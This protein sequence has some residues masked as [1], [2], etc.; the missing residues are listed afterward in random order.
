MGGF[1]LETTS[2]CLHVDG[3]RLYRDQV[4]GSEEEDSRLALCEATAMIMRQS[5]HLLGITP[6]MRI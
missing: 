2:T 1:I 6:L 3:L 5:F 4:L